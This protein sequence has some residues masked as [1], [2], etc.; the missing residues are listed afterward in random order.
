MVST[1]N[2][3][4]WHVLLRNTEEYKLS[5]FKV[6]CKLIHQYCSCHEIAPLQPQP[7]MHRPTYRPQYSSHE[8][9]AQIFLLCHM[10]RFSIESLCVHV[11]ACVCMHACAVC[12][13]GVCVGVWVHVVS[14]LFVFG[15][16]V[17]VVGYVITKFMLWFVCVWCGSVWGGG[18]GG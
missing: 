1:T 8:M 16:W 4:C 9:P 3:I 5:P 2:W 14:I 7:P 11:C 17:C 15:V 10:R 13:F 18:G 12:S 6:D